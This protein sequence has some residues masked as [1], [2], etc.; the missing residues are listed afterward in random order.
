MVRLAA[1]P[2]RPAPAGVGPASLLAGGETRVFAFT[3]P[4]A[5]RVGVG[6][7]ASADVVDADLLDATGARLADGRQALVDLKPGRYLLR[8]R[9]PAGR[10][11]VRIAP[12][13][14]GLK[15][16]GDGPPPTALTRLL[17]SAGLVPARA[18]E[19]K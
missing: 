7:R 15:P 6:V 1:D 19:G 12:V 3:V 17:D 16:P 13:V 8:V 9:C 4:T 2:I 10:G 11:P 5:R 18:P 14:L